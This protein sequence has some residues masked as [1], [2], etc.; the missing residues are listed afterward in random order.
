MAYF[1]YF[2]KR[3]EAIIFFEYEDTKSWKGYRLLEEHIAQL[4]PR[5]LASPEEK[6]PP[7]KTI[8]MNSLHWKYAIWAFSC[9]TAIRKK[10]I[11]KH[12]V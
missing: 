7:N 9:Y 6:I 10:E 3:T 1:V 4:E 5:Y 12:K 8:S 11:G 2:K